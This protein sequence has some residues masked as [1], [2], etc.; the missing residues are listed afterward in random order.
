MEDIKIKILLIS[1]AEAML[2]QDFPVE[3]FG[4]QKYLKWNL[5][6]FFGGH[7]SD[8]QL[9]AE[10]CMHAITNFSYKTKNCHSLL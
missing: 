10:S 3:Y 1:W 4:E 2:G 8:K 7:V 9:V 6:S 5:S